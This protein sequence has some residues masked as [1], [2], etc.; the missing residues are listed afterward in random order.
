MSR[1]H[2]VNSS[3]AALQLAAVALVSGSMAVAQGDVKPTN[4]APNP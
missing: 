2:R 4:D 3:A 1:T